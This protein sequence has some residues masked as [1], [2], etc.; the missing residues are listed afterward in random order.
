[1]LLNKAKPI[2]YPNKPPKT[3]NIV[4]TVA[5]KKAFVLLAS[6]IGIKIISGGIGKNELSIKEINAKNQDAYLFDDCSRVQLY[7]NR[8]TF[9]INVC[10]VGVEGIEPTPPK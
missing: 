3:E 10:L 2:K 8:K 6:I 1:M 4:Q 9:I 7:K 5:K